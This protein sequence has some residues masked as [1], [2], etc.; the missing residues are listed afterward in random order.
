[1]EKK[2]FPKGMYKYTQRDLKI[3]FQN[4]GGKI[5]E[6]YSMNK[7]EKLRTNKNAIFIEPSYS[8]VEIVKGAI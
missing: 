4:L 2:F 3:I 1:M 5:H 7:M 8:V 6:Y